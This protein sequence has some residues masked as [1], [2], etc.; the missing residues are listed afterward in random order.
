MFVNEFMSMKMHIWSVDI[1][2]VIG[3]IDVVYIFKIR[4]E[5]TWWLQR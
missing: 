4:P 3:R 5:T 2:S 1:S